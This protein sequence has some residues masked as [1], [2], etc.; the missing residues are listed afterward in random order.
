VAKSILA[1]DDEPSILKMLKIALE[2]QGYEVS[3]AGDGQ[4]ALDEIRSER[5]DLILLDLK[6]PRLGGY[7]L[8]AQ[9]KSNPDLKDIPI[10]VITAL[11]Q[12]SEHDDDE[13]ARRMGAEGFLTKP[14]DV[15]ELSRRVEEVVAK[16]L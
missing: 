7:Q 4:E 5:P 8:F 2:K 16:F 15:E 13:W 1:I 3:T 6:M 9:L 11:T 12:D 10:I 14:F